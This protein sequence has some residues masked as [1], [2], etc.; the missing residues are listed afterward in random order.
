MKVLDAIKGVEKNDILTLRLP[1]VFVSVGDEVL[2]YLPPQSPSGLVAPP[3]NGDLRVT[4]D[5]R[6]DSLPVV[7]L[8]ESAEPLWG[9]EPGDSLW[10]VV[11]PEA[12]KAQYRRPSS[13]TI[14][15]LIL[16]IAGGPYRPR[17]VPYELL[18]AAT[19]AVLDHP[20][21]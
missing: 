21:P 15:Q 1:D 17:V 11:S 5:S 4:R 13:E 16:E 18:R 10:K 6:H 14:H 19:L 9:D 12:F 3:L 7:Y 8:S 2:W 20:R